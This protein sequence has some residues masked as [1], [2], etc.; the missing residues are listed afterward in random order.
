MSVDICQ[1]I[2]DF[3]LITIVVLGIEAGI[4]DRIKH[5][6]MTWFTWIGRHWNNRKEKKAANKLTKK[7]DINETIFAEK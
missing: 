3:I 7:Q 1:A 2:A 5:K 4:Q 6:D